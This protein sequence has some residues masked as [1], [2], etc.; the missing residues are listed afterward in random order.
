MENNI[1]ILIIALLVLGY[2]YLS[3]LLMHY[4][5]SGPMIFTAVGVM[6]SPLGIATV[7]MH[8]QTEIVEIIAVIALIIVLFSD[9]STLNLKKLRMDWKIPARMLFIGLPLTIIATTYLATFFFP[10]ESTIYLL[11]M[12]FVLAP[13]DAALG[14]AVVLDKNV[15]EKIRTSINVESGLNDGIVFPLLLTVSA[16]IGSGLSEYQDNHWISYV[17]K[18]IA[19]GAIIGSVVGYLFAKIST[20]LTQKDWLESSYQNLIP[21]A[22]AI[23]S[24][25]TAEH[26]GGNGFIAAFFAGLLVG[27]VSQ[28]LRHNVKL[29]AESEGELLILISFM[30]FGI[31]FIP[32]TIAYWDLKTFTFALLSLSVLRMLPVAISLIGTKF[33]FSTILF[34]GWFGP[35]GIAS[36]LYVIIIIGRPEAIHG[37]ESIY[38]VIT[39]T[40]FLSIILHGLSAKPF[41]RLYAKSH[42]EKNI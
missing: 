26:F 9:A 8:L 11:L 12:A 42:K 6:L 36:I 27:S 32:A 15:P 10:N 13:T 7:D 41:A 20:T 29:F 39:L 4:N 37:H 30:V 17:A 22:I 3:K 24:Y 40:I 38:T 31:V 33:D 14:K 19:F 21:I 2:G 28:G 35:R 34:L 23:L 16:M 5:I 18:Q 1:T 25:Y